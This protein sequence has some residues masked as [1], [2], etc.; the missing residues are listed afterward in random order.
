MLHEDTST[1]CQISNMQESPF[2][3]SA[4]HAVSE[5]SAEHVLCHQWYIA[6]F[7]GFTNSS[8]GLSQ[9]LESF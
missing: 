4:P 5:Q 2:A 6:C 1:L 3:Y 7:T 8:M 9:T